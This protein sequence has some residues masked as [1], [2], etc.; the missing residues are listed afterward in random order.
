MRREN[1]P[2]GA[3][4]QTKPSML[5]KRFGELVKPAIRPPSHRRPSSMLETPK[6]VHFDPHLEHVRHFLQVDRPLS[7]SV[8]S[9]TYELPLDDDSRFSD[10]QYE[11]ELSL[12]NLPLNSTPRKVRPVYVE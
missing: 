5:R 4:I 8:G 1:S 10:K 11:W 3:E 12:S 2:D 9:P 7:V 6:A